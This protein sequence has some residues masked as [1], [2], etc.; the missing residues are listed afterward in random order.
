MTYGNRITKNL[1]VIA[2]LCCLVGA[3]K[4]SPK[5]SFKSEQL[6]LTWEVKERD[7]KHRAETR[8]ALTL[9]NNGKDSI[10]TKG[11]TI[12]FNAGNPRELNNDSSV[13]ILKQINGDFFSIQPGKQFKGIA[14][15]ESITLDILSRDLKNYTDQSKGFYIVFDTDP[16]QGFPL[17]VENKSLGDES[18]KE[19]ALAA[20][21][22]NLNK[23]IWPIPLDDLPPVFPTPVEYEHKN[24]NFNLNTATTI[25][26]DPLFG[27][28]AAYLAREILAVTGVEPKITT[29][30]ATTNNIELRKGEFSNQ[31][32][33][34]LDVDSN[35]IVITAAGNA[36]VFYGIQS[37]K[38]M[39]PAY[40][41]KEK[42]AEV[43]VPNVVIKD[44][45][46]FAHRAF[47]I[48]I[49]RNFQ[50]KEQIL[51][52][53]D[54]LSL[55]KINILH[56]HF[57]D[58]EGWRLE[59]PGLPEL[60]EVGSKRGH[61]T[62]GRDRL[63]PAYGSGPSTD[64]TSGS[65]H[66]SRADYIEI[67]KY[68]T[69]R[70]IMLIPELETPGHARAAIKSMDAR[71]YKLSEAG[72]DEEAQKYLLRDLHDKS[73]YTSIQGWND[74]VIN[75]AMPSVYNFMEKVTDELIAMHKEA[76]APLKTIHFGG[77][78]VPVGV[79]EQSP[80]V[81]DLLARDKTIGTVDEL[82][83]YYFSK[84][85][86]MLKSRN[87]Y[88]SGWEEIGLQKAL[89]DGQKKMVL[90][91]R[92]VNENYHADVWNNLQGNED[93][94]YKLANAG[95][96]VV[97][98]NVT[99][100]Y[101]D[102]AY[103]SSP[104]EPGQYWGGYVDVDKPFKFIPFNFYKN[105]TENERGEPITAE[106]FKSKDKLTAVGKSNIVGVQSPLWSEIITSKELFEHLL[107]PKV[108]GLAERAW[109]QDPQW[110]V[111]ENTKKSEELYQ[112]AWSIFVNQL[113]QRE[114]PRLDYYA[115]GFNYRIPT[116]G[117]VI[118]NK[119][120]LANVQ[121]IGFQIRYTADGSEPTGN[122]SVWTQAIPLTKE[123]SFRVFNTTGRGGRTVKINP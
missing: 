60:T 104:Y 74:N 52:L 91:K 100:F 72:K 7:F 114:L 14:T 120:V 101:L 90:D 122:S 12:Y 86:K 26:Y 62:T 67:L 109:A 39:F 25:T 57:N 106:H 20:K 81:A 28:E 113:A 93:L 110:A 68:A 78:E 77:D 16:N 123:M 33:Y 45:P 92:A 75:P 71:Y 55:Y 46:R 29:G 50:P 84:V 23:N 73:V 63:Y 44:H 35:N 31:E 65:G 27:N 11:W 49:A 30:L 34:Q 76:G 103:S 59:I 118:E 47:M 4:T 107:L 61:T 108:L 48:D 66:L 105:Q 10:P 41:W 19:V 51:K 115:G 21:Y 121:Y 87:L 96:K 5:S 43:M 112:K 85:N 53:I 116:P 88:L 6:G 37:L 58:D 117:L 42:L 40:A 18:I 94:A 22:Y 3:C 38:T 64:N 98:T 97:L 95:Y 32:A 36:G 80:V 99:N 89:V 15:G 111:E 79:W 13:L 70:H 56:F 82:W 17:Q 24:G 69:T 8:S 9:T 102:L 1:M 83:Y 119:K 2:I 54:L